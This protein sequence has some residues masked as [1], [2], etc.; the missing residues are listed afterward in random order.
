MARYDQVE[1][2]IG[3]IRAPLA[4]AL[5]FDANGEFGPGASSWVL[6]GSPVSPA[7]S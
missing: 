5:T 2:H 7:S 1:P 3:I 4:A 6:R